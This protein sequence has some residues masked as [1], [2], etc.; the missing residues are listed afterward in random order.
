MPDRP[1]VDLFSGERRNP[2][3]A[4]L[5]GRD[6]ML[7]FGG[8]EQYT[9]GFKL[10]A[11]QLV[12]GLGESRDAAWQKDFLLYPVGVLYRHYLELRLKKI[13]WAASGGKPPTSSHS[14]MIVWNQ[15]REVFKN[16]HPQDDELI[17]DHYERIASLLRPLD[18][19]D[20]NSQGFR[21]PF[22]KKGE[23]TISNDIER[24]ELQELKEQVAEISRL[25]DVLWR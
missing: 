3:S 8:W 5:K 13:Y 21:Y 9:P 18:Q 22:D 1:R 12:R 16:R 11:D 6:P 19:L 14:L 4:W 17:V 15:V 2:Y 25:L 24:I 23:L 7:G 10:A 20:P